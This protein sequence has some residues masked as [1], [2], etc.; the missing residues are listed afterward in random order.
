MGICKILWT[1]YIVTPLCAY[2]LLLTGVLMAL[3]TWT[4]PR[5]SPFITD[6]VVLMKGFMNL[7]MKWLYCC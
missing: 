1:I 3:I 4:D 7:A 2:S 5:V 6:T